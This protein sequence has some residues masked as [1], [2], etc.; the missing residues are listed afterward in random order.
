[1]PFDSL[2]LGIFVRTTWTL[3][4][5]LLLSGC[6]SL[7]RSKSVDAVSK[8]P[9]FDAAASET[10]VLNS[11]TPASDRDRWE[12]PDRPFIDWPD[13][14]L[15]TIIP[16]SARQPASGTPSNAPSGEKSMTPPDEPFHRTGAPGLKNT[17][18]K[19]SV[20]PAEDHGKS[21]QRAADRSV[22]KINGSDFSELVLESEVPVIVDFYADWCGPCKRL[23][24]ILD[25]FARETPNV[26]VVKVNIDDSKKIAKKYR[27]RSVPTLMVFKE[28]APVSHH[29]GLANKAELAK[30]LK[31]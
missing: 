31:R 29:T 23:S 14:N 22:E 16:V 2:P 15:G 21:A 5:V 20:Q 18:S 30:L 7:A 12:S 24:P 13:I 9:A 10:E 17:Q 27:V 3:L 25:Q 1:M 8:V 11:E 26:R 19:H 28:G 4:T 6:G